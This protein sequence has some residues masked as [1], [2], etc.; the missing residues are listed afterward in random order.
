MGTERACVRCRLLPH[1][2]IRNP[3]ELNVV[4]QFCGADVYQYASPNYLGFCRTFLGFARSR[5]G[6]A[7]AI[8]VKRRGHG[9]AIDRRPHDLLS[10][11]DIPAAVAREPQRF[12]SGHADFPT[13]FSFNRTTLTTVFRFVNHKQG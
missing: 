2:F 13:K 6:I 9:A 11:E 3:C 4:Y 7:A 12:H 10:S 5:P 1:S 8:R